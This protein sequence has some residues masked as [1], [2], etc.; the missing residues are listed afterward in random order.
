MKQCPYCSKQIKENDRFCLG[1]G[2]QVDIDTVEVS[3]AG[4]ISNLKQ[5]FGSFPIAKVE[6]YLCADEQKCSTFTA[7][8]KQNEI[9]NR[10]AKIDDIHSALVDMN[11]TLNYIRRSLSAIND[12]IKD[13]NSN[14][15][16]LK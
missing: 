2:R 14:A 16:R 9:I 11:E 3:Q 15:K 8:T 6:C 10:L 7:N 1:C 13:M 12:N 5:C 4:G